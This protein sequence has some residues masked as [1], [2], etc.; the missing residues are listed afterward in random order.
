MARYAESRGVLLAALARAGFRRCSAAD[1][2]F[3]VYVDVAH[4]T[5][6]SVAFCRDLL[7]RTGVAATPGVD[8][9]KARGHLWVRF[10]YCGAVATVRE[11]AARLER[12]AAEDGWAAKAGGAAAG[13][14]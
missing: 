7:A 1:G 9:D 11:A 2:A 5:G 8:F 10:S 4:L 12:L 3:Y 13:A 6:D 14:S